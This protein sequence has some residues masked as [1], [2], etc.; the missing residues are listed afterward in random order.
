MGMG[1]SFKI[2]MKMKRKEFRNA[3]LGFQKLKSG[4]RVACRDF[5]FRNPNFEL[6]ISLSA[7]GPVHF[8]LQACF[9]LRLGG[10][11]VFD[12]VAILKTYGWRDFEPRS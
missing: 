3:N 6:S 11:V 8:P 4:K 7:D 12:G 5:E 10:W 9:L 1:V 2:K